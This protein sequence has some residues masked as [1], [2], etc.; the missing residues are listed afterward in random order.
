[1]SSAGRSRATPHC[2]GTD[3]L[4]DSAKILQT[5]TW[6]IWLLGFF[7]CVAIGGGS[8]WL[9]AMNQDIHEAQT[10]IVTL[11][12]AYGQTQVELSNIKQALRS[13]QHDLAAIREL[14]EGYWRR[15][16]TAR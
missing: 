2:W 4:N 16:E 15:E 14:M 12:V 8:A 7:A 6:T 5:P 1:M 10:D 9:T 13:M 11:K 3:H